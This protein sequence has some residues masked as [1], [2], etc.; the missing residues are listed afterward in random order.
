MPTQF[1]ILV[2]TDRPA[3]GLFFTGMGRRRSDGVSTTVVEP[4]PDSLERAA[5]AVAAASVAVVD[6]ST[7]PAEAGEMCGALRAQRPDLPIAILF[8]CP[9]SATRSNLRSF[10]AIGIA[11][12]LDLQLSAHR[13]LNA[14]RAVARGEDVVYLQLA[15]ETVTTLFDGRNGDHELDED[16]R[17]LLQLV[18]AGMTDHEIGVEMY[19]SQHTIKHRI[20]RLRRRVHARNRIQLAAWAASH[21]ELAHTITPTTSRTSARA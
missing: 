10:I 14:L 3:V 18:A 5:G 4:G 15:G 17:V 20:E 13:A 1:R 8:C 12:F 21:L 6:A 9:C 16:E 19:L 2:T 11:S 7:D